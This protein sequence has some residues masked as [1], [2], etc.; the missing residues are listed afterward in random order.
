MARL[1]QDSAILWR[2]AAYDPETFDV[3]WE[4]VALDYVTVVCT[5]AADGAGKTEDRCVVYVK[6]GTSLV[7]GVVY[8]GGALCAPGDRLIPWPAVTGSALPADDGYRVAAI[9]K[10]VQGT[11]RIRHAKLVAR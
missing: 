9:E 5:R 7:D 4:C 8:R 3:E 10:R 2:R 1:W 6:E 11:D